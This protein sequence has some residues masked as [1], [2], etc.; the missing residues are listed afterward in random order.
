[1][2]YVLTLACL[3]AL[4]CLLFQCAETGD[5]GE[6]GETPAATYQDTVDRGAYLVHAMGCR[7]CHSPKQMGAQGPEDI[8]GLELSGFRGD[9]PVPTPPAG[10]VEQGWMLFNPDLTA[11]VGPWGMSFSANITSDETGIG[12]WTFEQFL[13]AIREGKSKGLRD[14]R[15]LLPPM[16]WTEYRLLT[17]ED[18]ASIFAYLKSTPP[19]KNVVPPPVPP[20]APAE[21]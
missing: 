19:V 21:G 10:V 3:C 14:N 7:D 11:A 18:L 6:N 13:V 20:A 8:K 4:A 12:N 2:K 17:D 1:M 9:Q 15:D 5:A 16:P